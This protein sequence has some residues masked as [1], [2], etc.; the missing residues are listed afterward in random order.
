VVATRGLNTRRWTGSGETSV[1]QVSDSS[2]NG[3]ANPR[4]VS[5]GG[6]GAVKRIDEFSVFA[7]ADCRM[8]LTQSP[9]APP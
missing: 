5:Y 1:A 7:G 2:G 9:S 6:I 4:R 3:L 8:P